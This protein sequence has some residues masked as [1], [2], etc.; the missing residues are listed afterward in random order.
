MGEGFKNSNNFVISIELFATEV[1][2]TRSLRLGESICLSNEN[3][4][5]IL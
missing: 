4:T 2:L 5:I 1:G 3:D